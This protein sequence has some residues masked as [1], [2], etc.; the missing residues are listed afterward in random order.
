MNSSTTVEY[1]SSRENLSDSQRYFVYCVLIYN[2]GL[3]QILPKSTL[4]RCCQNLLVVSSQESTPNLSTCYHR[5]PYGTSARE[6]GG[7]GAYAVD[8]LPC[9]GETDG[10]LKNIL[11]CFAVA[12]MGNSKSDIKQGSKILRSSDQ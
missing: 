1:V 5:D 12:V 8:M 2:D 11:N 4:D 10:V 6:N 9:F 3:S 7:I